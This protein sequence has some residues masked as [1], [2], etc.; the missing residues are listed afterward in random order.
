MVLENDSG[1]Y[2]KTDVEVIQTVAAV[3]E[4]VSLLEQLNTVSGI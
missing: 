4:M 3:P 2:N 1:L